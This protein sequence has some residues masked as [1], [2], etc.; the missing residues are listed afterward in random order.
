M[1][2][3]LDPGRPQQTNWYATFVSTLENV[4]HYHEQVEFHRE[5]AAFVPNGLGDVLLN[6]AE[7]YLQQ[8]R[9]ALFLLFQWPRVNDADSNDIHKI[10]QNEYHLWV[11]LNLAARFEIPFYVYER[12]VLEGL[13]HQTF[14]LLMVQK[15]LQSIPSHRR[16][17][18]EGD[19]YARLFSEMLYLWD[20]ADLTLRNRLYPVVRHLQTVM[21]RADVIQEVEDHYVDDIIMGRIP[22]TLI[23]TLVDQYDLMNPSS[24]AHIDARIERRREI[25]RHRSRRRKTRRH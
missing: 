4:D 11:F 22:G 24:K 18:V 15:I 1:S 8:S 9:Q 20:H 2:S 21:T 14:D 16:V 25:E 23:L 13:R 10:A 5:R 19:N 3:W 6:N 12:L 7:E 17:T